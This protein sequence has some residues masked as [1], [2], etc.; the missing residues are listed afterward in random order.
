MI[1]IRYPEM[2][3]TEDEELNK[4]KNYLYQLA[5]QL[6]WA[7]STLDTGAIQAEEGA[8][9]ETVE[10]SLRRMLNQKIKE[11]EQQASR[12]NE[13]FK[14][15]RSGNITGDVNFTGAVNINGQSLEEYI[16]SITGGE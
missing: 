11:V 5:E 3:R 8:D 16:R 2:G 4:L 12:A 13:V 10:R 7:F 1:D 6:N 9:A 15:D 14:F